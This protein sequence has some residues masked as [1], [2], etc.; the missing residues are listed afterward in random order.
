MNKSSYKRQ[1]WKVNIL[2]LLS[3]FALYGLAFL[4]IFLAAI[5]IVEFISEKPIAIIGCVFLIA[6]GNG[7]L[8]RAIQ[9][10]Q[11]HWKKSLQ[12]LKDIYEPKSSSK[13]SIHS[14]I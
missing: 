5:G 6:L 4:S 1:I 7:F 10:V 8:R 12:R 14:V 2:H 9:D 11:Q 13:Q 3:I